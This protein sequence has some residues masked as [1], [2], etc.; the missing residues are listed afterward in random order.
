M[1]TFLPV[2]STNVSNLLG[3]AV[4]SYMQLGSKGV[5][6]MAHL[7]PTASHSQGK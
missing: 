1:K 5:L 4:V 6:S 3:L 7:S 2:N